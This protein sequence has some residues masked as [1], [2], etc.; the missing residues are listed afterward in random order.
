MKKIIMLVVIF[1]VS[2]FVFLDVNADE[3]D[4]F[5]VNGVGYSSFE[6]ALSAVPNNGEIILEKDFSTSDTIKINTDK[7]ISFNMNGYSIICPSVSGVINVLKGNV[8]IYDNVGTSVIQSTAFDSGFAKTVYVY[9]KYSSYDTKVTISNISIVSNYYGV[10]LGKGGDVTLNNVNINS[11][12]N[13]V[14][15]NNS[16][17]YINGGIYYANEYNIFGVDATTVDNNVIE[18]TSGSF[19]SQLGTLAFSDA[20]SNKVGKFI[21][22]GTFDHDISEYVQDDFTVI[23]DNGNYVVIDPNSIVDNSTDTSTDNS[24]DNIDLDALINEY[25]D[26]LNGLDDRENALNDRENE[27]NNREN[28][29]DNRENTLDNKENNLN[30]LENDLNNREDTLD[31]REN[32][33]DDRENSLDNRE[34]DLNDLENDLN[35]KEDS[36]DNRENALDD[37][38]NSLDDRENTLDD[39]E[40]SLDDRENTLDDRENNLNDREDS[41]DDRENSLDNREEK[42]NNK[43]NTLNELEDELN[44]REQELIEREKQL[45]VQTNTNSPSPVNYIIINHYIDNSSN[46]NTNNDDTDSRN[47]SLRVDYNYLDNVEDNS[48]DEIKDEYNIDYLINVDCF[49]YDNDTSSVINKLTQLNKKI[50]VKIQLPE[51]YNPGSYIYVAKYHNNK[52]E[53][54]KATVTEDNMLTFETSQFSLFAIVSPKTVESMT[55]D[56]VPSAADSVGRI[57]RIS[58]INN[59]WLL[60]ISLILIPVYVVMRKKAK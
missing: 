16:K 44:N 59:V 32:S 41:L 25:E 43:E 17:V 27:L 39:R 47:V 23:I 7:S 24:L 26:R 45:N 50:H 19:A 6:S 13:V 8:N 40:N 48:F 18:L 55:L 30:D 9:K 4:P 12:Y 38:E 28:E 52:V 10:Y 36:L 1:I 57:N 46:N 2:A 54:I 49:L 5:S 60:I 56:F 22:G 42:L 34:N 14:I 21:S 15:G 33:L 37:R 31:N 53:L 35:N 11:T 51:D 20:L 58:N 29:L 3:L